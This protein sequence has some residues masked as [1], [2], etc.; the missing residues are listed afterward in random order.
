MIGDR[1]PVMTFRGM[2]R[3][4]PNLELYV[5]GLREKHVLLGCGHWIQRER[6]EE[7]YAALIRFGRSGFN[8]HDQML[9]PGG[10]SSDRLTHAPGI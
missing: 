5:P 10:A 7:V 2:D 6:S 1:D 4:I 9:Q 8:H 3:L